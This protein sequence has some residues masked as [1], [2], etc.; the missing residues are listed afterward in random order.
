MALG[1]YHHISLVQNEHFDFLGIYEF[2][3]GTPVQHSAGCADHDL[4]RD[5][6]TS[7]HC[8]DTK[9]SFPK[10]AEP[11]LKCAAPLQTRLFHQ[12]IIHF[13]YCTQRTSL[14]HLSAPFRFTHIY[15][16]GRRRQVSAPDKTFPSVQSLFLFEVPARRLGKGTNTGGTEG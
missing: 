13:L 14:S 10:M 11:T 9:E 5:L 4:L 12:L 7:L 1:C 2:E 16:L 6:L 15:C 8:R 3:F